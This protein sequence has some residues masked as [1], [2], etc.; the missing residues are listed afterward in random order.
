MELRHLRYF[1]AVVEE[2][3]LTV[4]AQR[5]LHT[6]QPS[7]SRQIRDLEH[8]VGATL[9]T[10]SVQGIELTPAGQAFLDHARLALAQVGAAVE[11]A[12]RAARPARQQFALGFLT[13]QE[14]DWMPEAMQI[15]KGDLHSMDVIVTSQYSPELAQGL[16]SGRLDMAFLREEAGFPDIEY[17]QV[18]REPL[19]VVLPSDHALASREVIGIEELRDE[20]LIGVSDTAPVL[21]RILDAYLARS[22]V[23]LRSAHLA[24]NIGMFLSLVASTRGIALMPLYTTHFLPWSVTSRP[25][26]GEVPTIDLMVGYH[27][28]NTSPVLKLFLS[29]LDE[30]IGRVAGKSS[31]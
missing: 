25:L 4:A 9:L 17:R 27:R 29:R 7:L 16:L 15:L 31:R 12:R 21:Q 11:A 10:R 22:G 26:A 20:L 2:G 19:V 8:E 30:L 23:T 5:R 14:M 6:S 28:E 1:V 18:H 24:D 13:G 3:S